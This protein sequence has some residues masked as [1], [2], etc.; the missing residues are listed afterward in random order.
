M[1][2]RLTCVPISALALLLS[3]CGGDLPLALSGAAAPAARV[4]SYDPLAPAVETVPLDLALKQA[5]AIASDGY[6]LTALG[7]GNQP[8]TDVLAAL[9]LAEKDGALT[10]RTTRNLKAVALYLSYDA[11]AQRVSRIDAGRDDAVSLA[12]VAE[13][14]LIAIGLAATSE[15]GLDPAAPIAAVQFSKGLE[16]ALRRASAISQVDSTA[17]RDLVAAYEGF[18]TATLNWHERHT[19]DYNLD[20]EVNLSD[21]TPIGFWYQEAVVPETENWAET[22]VVDG[23]EDGLITINDIT[24]IGQN[25][26]S[27]L[28]GYNV[29]RMELATPEDE[30]TPA[31]EG[32]VKVENEAEPA[33]P[34]AP[35]EGMYNGQKTRLEWT[36]LEEPETGF[37]A[38]YVVPTGRAGETPYEGPPSNV[39]KPEG[40]V[41]P[42]VTL[43][44]EIQPPAGEL[45]NVDQEF[46]LGVKV[47]DV[48]NL[49][50]ANVRFE[51]DATLVEFIEAVPFY[52][53]TTEHANLLTDPES[54]DPP[55]ENPL[56]IGGDVGEAEGG[57]GYRLVGFN[58]TKKKGD[59]PRSGTGF[60]G[61][62]KFRAIDARIN[63]ECFRFP[64][65]T[66]YIYLWGP[67]YGVPVATP[68]PGGP[69]LVNI[70]E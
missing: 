53:D 42:N 38:W 24:Q 64:Q 32:W 45:L 28:T 31:D 15:A 20:G 22:E 25:F 27:F 36:F 39:A 2:R 58:A 44:F 40:G 62:A 11:Q 46:Y 18:G 29:Y 41:V 8:A 21:L 51:Y 52:T 34:S 1:T 49:F 12:F 55:E 33:G 9:E 70:A 7:A 30:P 26:R 35:R 43:T 60:V 3:A 37:Y 19:G 17:V 69:Q 13:P 68:V 54:A 6:R 67:L 4:C 63:N 16:T 50:S 61:Y 57:A 59:D 66:T 47:T 56:F 5:P 65:V 48:A 10:I 23:T 14:G